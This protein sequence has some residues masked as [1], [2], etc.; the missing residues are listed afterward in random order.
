MSEEHEVNDEY[1]DN[2]TGTGTP[3][4]SLYEIKIPEQ[5]EISV[6]EMLEMATLAGEMKSAQDEFAASVGQCTEAMD[7]LDDIS[8]EL[9]ILETKYAKRVSEYD[10][11]RRRDVWI[12]VGLLVVSGLFMLL[13]VYAG[14][15]AW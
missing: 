11:A 10:R 6:A 12:L 3:G 13:S 1:G 5:V 8:Q 2:V 9:E 4:W 7:A 14:S 15:W